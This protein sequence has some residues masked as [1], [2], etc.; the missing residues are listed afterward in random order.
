[1][2]RLLAAALLL[3]ECLEVRAPLLLLGL[4]C[5]LGG[6]SLALRSHG[7]PTDTAGWLKRLQLSAAATRAAVA[8]RWLSEGLRLRSGE[9]RLTRVGNWPW[10]SPA[11]RRRR[12]LSS[13]ILRSMV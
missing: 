9:G 10:R 8:L 1:M 3:L 13:V 6:S 12:C 2:V 7:L 5:R 4:L 11:R